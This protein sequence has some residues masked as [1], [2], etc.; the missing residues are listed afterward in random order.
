MPDIVLYAGGDELTETFFKPLEKDWPRGTARPTYVA[1]NGLTGVSK[2]AAFFTWLGRDAELR[3]RFIGIAA[4]ANT[5][6]NARFT[7]RYNQAYPDH[8]T[9]TNL[10]PAAPYD[11]FYLVAYAAFVAGDGALRGPDLARS[12]AALLSPG[13]RIEVGPT[14][15]LDAVATLRAGGHIDLNGAGGP[16]DFD[17]ATGESPADF[18]FVCPGRDAKGNADAEVESGL[19]FASAD[20]ALRGTIR[21]P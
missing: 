21:C 5:A 1:L 19:S 17:L 18:V 3:H 12:I 4:P 11:A 8:A 9:T 2:E 10:S 7:T 13:K 20:H 14:A 6:T 16:L 15:I